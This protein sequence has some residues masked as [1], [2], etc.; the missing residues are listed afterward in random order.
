[1][2]Y[3]GRELAAARRAYDVCIIGSGPAGMTTALELK[4]SGLTICLLE[5]GDDS[6]LL[7]WQH[8]PI[9][10][11]GIQIRP[12]S[13]ER[14]L[15]GT[16]ATWAGLMAPLDEIDFEPRPRVHDGWPVGRD[17]IQKYVDERGHRYMLPG[18]D[19]FRCPEQCRPAGRGRFPQMPHLSKKVFLAQRTPLR[20]GKAFA[21]A[22][23]DEGFDLYLRA[24]V[25][26]LECRVPGE[27][28]F[29]QVEDS[30]G[31][32][33]LVRARCFVLAASTIENVRLLLSSNL[34]NEHDQ[35]GRYFMNHPKG[36]IARVSFKPPL[37]SSCEL[38]EHGRGDFAGYVGFRLSETLQRSEDLLNASIRFDP[39]GRRD[40]PRGKALGKALQRFVRGIAAGNPRSVMGSARRAVRALDGAPELAAYAAEKV[41]T[42]RGQV[43]ANATVRCFLEMEPQAENRIVLHGDGTVRIQQSISPKAYASA[44]RLL[45]LTTAALASQGLGTVEPVRGGIEGALVEDASHHLGGA[46]MGKDP[47]SS[48]VDPSLRIHT[49]SN[50][51]VA[52]GAVFPTSGSANPT[53]TIIALSIRL[54]DHIRERLRSSLAA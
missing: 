39:G 12:D 20:Y 46:R 21:D 9:E 22:F 4:S 17:E 5:A 45:E 31:R 51:F 38:F 14:T 37:A 42:R 19:A 50:V 28:A 25:R 13:R 33:H 53:M 34:G 16:S 49:T 8:P 30:T 2:K 47:Q 27:A 1:M 35:V 54:A 26:R 36:Y 32:R 29:A 23:L 43:V 18:S 24:N 48:V 44:R 52:G 11:G 3:D 7:D 15:G 40:Y 6:P 41:L 10:C